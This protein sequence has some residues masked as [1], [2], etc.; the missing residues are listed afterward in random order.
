MSLLLL[1]SLLFQAHVLL[2]ALGKINSCR[3]VLF[4]VT[5]MKKR[6]CI[7][8]YDSYSST[9]AAIHSCTYPRMFTIMHA[10][11][12]IR[13]QS[14]ATLLSN[15]VCFI[16]LDTRFS[17]LETM[18]LSTNLNKNT[19]VF[20]TYE[21][22]FFQ[23][24]KIHIYTILLYTHCMDKIIIVELNKLRQVQKVSYT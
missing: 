14:R 23:H 8:F 9:V 5:F 4:Q 12:Q 15:Y 3:K 6:F 18:Q 21:H 11:I 22:I 24:F 13:T 1:E 7:A 20:T 10:R 16:F 19:H 2:Q 17:G